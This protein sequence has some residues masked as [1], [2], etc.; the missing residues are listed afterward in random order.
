MADFTKKNY[1]DLS[2]LQTFWAQI[3]NQMYLKGEVDSAISSAKSDLQ[4]KIDL[5]LDTA[6]FNSTIAGYYTKGEVDGIKSGLEGQIQGVDGKFASYTNTEGMNSAISSAVSSAKSELTGTINGVD[7]K[8]ANYYDKDAVD[9]IVEGLEGSISDVDAK[10]ASYT[11][12]EGMNSAISSAVSGAQTTLQGNID[13]VAGRVKALED[14]DFPKQISDAV[15]AQAALDKAAWEKADADL[16][17]DLEG[18]IAALTHLSVSIVESLPATGELGVIYLVADTFSG[19]YVE[20]LWTGTAFEKIGTT[21]T[22][23]NDYYTKGEVDG[24]INGLGDTY[25]TETEIDGKVS[26]LEGSINGVAGDLADLAGRVE[27]IEN[28]GGEVNVIEVVKVN[29]TAL[30]VSS[31]DRSVNVDLSAYALSETV[32]SNLSSAVS[33]LEGQ[34]NGVDAKFAGYYTKGEVDSI[35]SGLEGKIAL[36]LDAS[37]ISAYATT[38]A[39]TSAVNG[40]KNNEIKAAQDAADAA[41]SAARS[42]PSTE[43]S[44][45]PAWPLRFRR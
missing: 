25:Y 43:H 17:S 1:V 27:D 33:T 4:G 44:G 42:E 18:Q 14:A 9:G 30:E 21:K 40:L 10:F 41:A 24:I 3:K 22:D 26:A 5:K 16:K 23:L 34:I 39:L 36:K 20:Y 13:G 45:P 12:T 8:F 37:A 19:S 38:E 35:E 32:A 7:A 6:T 15:A 2:G 28:I 31:A 11:N 29:G